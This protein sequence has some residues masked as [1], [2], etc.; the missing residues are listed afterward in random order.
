MSSKAARVADRRKAIARKL[1]DKAAQQLIEIKAQEVSP[2]KR[3]R[4]LHALL[5]DTERILVH[6]IRA[7]NR[8][9]ALLRIIS[10]HRSNQERRRNISC[11]IR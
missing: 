1:E 2:R 10:K 6:R 3:R 5:G 7:H 8:I 11:N 9:R 4:H